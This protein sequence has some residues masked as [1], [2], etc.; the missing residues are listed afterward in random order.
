MAAMLGLLRPTRLI[1]IALVGGGIF[2]WTYWTRAHRTTEVSQSSAIER[3]RESAGQGGRGVG[4]P[5]SGVYTYRQ[6]GD[7][8]G[9]FG[10]LGIDRTLPNEA[11]LTIRLMDGGYLQQ[12][13]LAREHIEARRFRVTSEGSRVTWIRTKISFATFGRDDRRTTK[14]QPVGTPGKLR[15]GQVW[16]EKYQ[17]GDLPV[18]AASRVLRRE[19]VSV[20][21]TAVETFVIQTRSVTGGSHPGTE[22]DTT[23]WSPR[24]RLPLRLKLERRIRGAAGFKVDAD[25]ALTSLRPAR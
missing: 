17:T 20:D 23:W 11:R 18:A 15:V 24:Y 14:P 19:T 25:L 16:A 22:I 2:G 4:I 21:G 12:L 7:E 3:F 10:P 9:S 8:R 1:A 13:D 6:A 5:E